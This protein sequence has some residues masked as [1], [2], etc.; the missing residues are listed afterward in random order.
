MIPIC[1]MASAR[2]TFLLFRPLNFNADVD[3]VNFLRHIGIES[4][5]NV[6][7]GILHEKKIIVLGSSL[8]EVSTCVETL[9]IMLNPFIW[10]HTLV[11]DEIISK[12]LSHVR[13]LI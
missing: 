8:A 2:T 7:H 9:S 11:K 12:V 5:L 10:Q 13:L 6:L 3:Y 1:Q 4:L